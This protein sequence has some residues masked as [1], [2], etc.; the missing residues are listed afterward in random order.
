[1]N[2]AH[3]Q[4]IERFYQAFNDGDGKVMAACY[5][6]NIHFSDPVF[7]DLRGERA[8]AMWQML[9]E[10]P[11]EVRVELLEHEADDTVGA[12][13]W[14]AH[15]TFSGTGRPVVNDIQATFTFKN[16]LIVEHHDDFD[17]YAWSRQALG[18]TGV[19]LGWTPIVKSAVRKKAAGMLEKYTGTARNGEA[20]TG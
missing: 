10:G 8:G 3:V 20:G 12:A 1:M 5:A 15:Y 9:T 18:L 7:T 17:F 14:K 6:P 4:L 19:L 2:D 13:H 11:G 16:G